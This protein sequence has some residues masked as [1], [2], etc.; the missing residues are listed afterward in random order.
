MDQD[1]SLWH[2][3]IIVCDYYHPTIA[4]ITISVGCSLRNLQNSDTFVL[5]VDAILRTSMARAF[6][7]CNLKKKISMIV[8]EKHYTQIQ[9]Q[10]LGSKNYTG[11]V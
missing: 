8:N 1:H 7:D 4:P 11:I 9:V 5:I 3:N 2:K 10:R 6:I